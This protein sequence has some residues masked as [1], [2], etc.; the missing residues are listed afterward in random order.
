MAAPIIASFTPYKGPIGTTI[1]LVGSGFTGATIVTFDGNAATFTVVNATEIS[2]IVPTTTTSN[3]IAVTNADGTGTSATNFVIDPYLAFQPCGGGAVSRNTP[4]TWAAVR[5]GVGTAAALINVADHALVGFYCSTPEAVYDWMSRAIFMF[6]TS[7]IPDGAVILSAS[8]HLWG[9]G[10]SSTL[11]VDHDINVFDV[12]TTSSDSTLAASDYS[13]LG[14]TAL[15]TAI[16]WSSFD[17]AAY[18]DFAFNLAGL[19]NINT[20]GVTKLGL[21]N[22]NFDAENVEPTAAYSGSAYFSFDIAAI[23]VYEPVLVVEVDTDPLTVDV[24]I[25]WVDE[26]TVLVTPT[27]DPGGHTVA[28]VTLTWDGNTFSVTETSLEMDIT[29]AGD[30]TAIVTVTDETA[31]VSTKVVVFNGDSYPGY[32]GDPAYPSDVITNTIVRLMEG[33]TDLAGAAIAWHYTTGDTQYPD[34]S[35]SKTLR[36]ITLTAGQSKP[37]SG[38]TLLASA[39]VTLT[40]DGVAATG[41]LCTINASHQSGRVLPNADK[42]CQRYALTVSGSTT[43]GGEIETIEIIPAVRGLR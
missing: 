7:M 33:C 36:E 11:S 29:H 2:V 39:L 30:T 37:E 16:L 8:L 32:P 1:R 35:V 27:I 15:S 25:A 31:I 23:N 20:T 10:I 26:H 4:G 40:R 9:D 24:D 19:G 12:G 21:R 38:E 18:N 22:S 17:P 13:T 43:T 34:P 3:P 5:D 28:D 6:D 42:P 41:Q 14:A